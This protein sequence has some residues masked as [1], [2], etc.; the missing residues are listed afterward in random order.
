MTLQLTANH[1]NQYR[2]WQSVSLRAVALHAVAIHGDYH[3]SLRRKLSHAMATTASYCTCKVLQAI[4]AIASY[5][6]LLQLLQPIASQAIAGIAMYDIASYCKS[7]SGYFKPLL[8]VIALALQVS[9]NIA[10]YCIARH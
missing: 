2:L 4:V 9:A 8:L 3:R 1:Y 5:C 7:L 6:M 10:S